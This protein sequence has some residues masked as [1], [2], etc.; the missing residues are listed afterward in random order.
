MTH[1]SKGWKVLETATSHLKGPCSLT[2]LY[3]CLESSLSLQNNNTQ[4][5]SHMGEM[6]F[7]TTSEELSSKDVISNLGEMFKTVTAKN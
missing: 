3:D 7:S 1:Q 2:W 6:G 5:Q 4:S